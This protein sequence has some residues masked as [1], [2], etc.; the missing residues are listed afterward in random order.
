MPLKKILTLIKIIRKISYKIILVFLYRFKLKVFISFGSDFFCSILE[1]RNN[2]RTGTDISFSH[3]GLGTYIGK[4]CTLTN[5]KIGR[6][7]SI[8]NNVKILLNN[9]P[10]SYISTHP[11]FHRGNN[12]MM[13]K[14]GLS[15]NVDCIYS[16]MN[17][18][19]DINQ[20]IIGSDV[21]IGEDVKII[22]G[23][24]IGDGCV[25]AAGSV[26]TKNVDSYT[27]VGGIPAR[28]IKKRFSDDEIKHLL[29]IQ[30]WNWTL[31]DIKKRQKDFVSIEAFLKIKN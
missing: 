8:A 2:I 5:I 25:I 13:K 20:V 7:C 9:H 10:L 12:K 4:N 16:E 21:W 11:C 30:W 6:F 19:D 28:E 26:V 31:I 3:I 27:I 23:V 1:G 24:T 22:S 15:F 17:L 14:L 29:E 18:I